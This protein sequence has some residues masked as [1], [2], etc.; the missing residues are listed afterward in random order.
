[1]LQFR[2]VQNPW[3]QLSPDSARV[4]E[5]DQA[6][7]GKFNKS[8]N[9]QGKRTVVTESLPEPFIGNPDSATLVFLGLN[10]GH[11]IDDQN[12]Y[13][14]ET[15]RAAIF[16][17]LHREQRG[18]PF[19]P[20]N[21]KFECTPTAK[22]WRPRTDKLRVAAGLTDEQFA[23]KLLVVE[24]FPYHSERC[25]LPAKQ[26]CESQAYS[27]WLARDMIIQGKLVVGM[28]SRKHWAVAGEEL[29]TAPYLKNPQCGFITRTN[30]EGNLFDQMVEA[31]NR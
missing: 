18:C 28:R 15:F 17:N 10:P 19:Y 6:C 13:K 27:F 14:N 2:A 25:G 30:T 26:M 16:Q 12:A 21:P 3:L 20:W 1:M 4:L 9:G 31:L 29:Q 8:R 7:V 24:W 5:M 11:S 22:W 23:E